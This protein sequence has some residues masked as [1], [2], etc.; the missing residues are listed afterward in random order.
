MLETGAPLLGSGVAGEKARLGV[1]FA[2]SV[3]FGVNSG[4][5]YLLMLTI[6]SFNGGV[7]LAIV[8]GL[9]VGY[10]LFRNEREDDAVVVDSSCACA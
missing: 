3:L 5:G 4:I 2:E 9:T 8:V 6:M 10:F 1:K 7:F